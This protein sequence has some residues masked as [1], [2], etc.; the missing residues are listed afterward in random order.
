[1]NFLYRKRKKSILLFNKEEG[2]NKNCLID[3]LCSRYKYNDVVY[4]ENDK[5]VKMFMDSV[6]DN[7]SVFIWCYEREKSKWIYKMIHTKKNLNIFL[8]MDYDCP[9]KFLSFCSDSP[10]RPMIQYNFHNFH[11]RI[12]FFTIQPISCCFES[13]SV[14]SV[15]L[16]FLLEQKKI[17]SSREILRNCFYLLKQNQKY[18]QPQFH[19]SHE[20]LESFEL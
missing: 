1:M 2:V 17:I 12:V 18:L 19:Y 7:D 9:Q 14:I 6:M 20:S 5:D 15:F 13:S 3:V 16:I 4:I 8:L 11:S 10:F